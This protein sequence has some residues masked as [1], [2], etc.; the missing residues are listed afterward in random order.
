MDELLGLEI[1]VVMII[2]FRVGYKKG[3]SIGYSDYMKCNL[4]KNVTNR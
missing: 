3:F 2:S 1:I 4:Q